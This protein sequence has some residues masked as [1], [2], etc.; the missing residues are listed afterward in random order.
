[1]R[2]SEEQTP[3]RN[4]EEGWAG[5]RGG[6]DDDFSEEDFFEKDFPV[7]DLTTRVEDL[8]DL[9]TPVE[10]CRGQQ[11]ER[12]GSR[13]KRTPL[14]GQDG[15]LGIPI[16]A[17]DEKVIYQKILFSILY[18]IYTIS[19]IAFKLREGVKKKPLNL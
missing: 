2:L 15:N 1:M 11:G 8:T 5:E 19:A 3:R 9:T 13:V 7:E 18:N 12:M 6:G 10:D 17:R 16:I 4:S 14:F